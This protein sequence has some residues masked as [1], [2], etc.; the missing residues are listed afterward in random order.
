MVL[1]YVLSAIQVGHSTKALARHGIQIHVLAPTEW[2]PQ[3]ELALPPVLPSVR[4]AML[5]LLSTV[6]RAR[7]TRVLAQMGLLP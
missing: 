3:G 2:L 7:P 5:A 6:T 1:S 4:L